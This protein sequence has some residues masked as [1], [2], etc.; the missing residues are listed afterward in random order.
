MLN[1]YLKVDYTDKVC[2]TLI[3][4][5]AN[6]LKKL[7]VPGTVAKTMLIAMC[8][9][10]ET[11]SGKA[12]IKR[13]YGF[14]DDFK[15]SSI[16]QKSDK[17]IIKSLMMQE[18]AHE[19][20]E[21]GQKKLK[22]SVATSSND[23]SVM[24]GSDVEEDRIEPKKN[25]WQGW[26]EFLNIAQN[27]N[28][29]PSLS[30]EKH[31]VIWYGINLR[32]RPS[33]PEGLYTRM[34]YETTA[35]KQ[36]NFSNSYKEAVK[37]IIQSTSR[38]HMLGSIEDLRSAEGNVVE[39]KTLIDFFMLFGEEIYDDVGDTLSESEACLNINL[40]KPCLQACSRMLRNKKYDIHE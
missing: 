3:L 14:A 11:T 21:R 20:D 2:E 38:N 10:N 32:H 16:K 34:K 9:F 22:T 8:R 26:K 29:L 35:I 17:A 27:N 31:G 18:V 15:N 36:Y 37:N 33:L 6:N 19:E 13:F 23:R 28:Y 24:S 30:P 25:I 4:P 39:K 12:A 5:N 7:I 40:I 1:K